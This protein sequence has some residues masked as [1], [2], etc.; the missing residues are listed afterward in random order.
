LHAADSG[1]LEGMTIGTSL[2]VI[3]VGAILKYAVTREKI[4]GVNI[5]TAGVILMVVGVVGLVLGLF[6]YSRADREP[7]PP[8]RV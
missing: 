3:A 1:Y 2:F 5:D 8:R 4:E 7:L 6:L